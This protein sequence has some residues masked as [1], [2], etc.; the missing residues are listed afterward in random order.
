MSV[1]SGRII[2]G[3]SGATYR[4]AAPQS[5]T[6]YRTE[7]FRST[8]GYRGGT[9]ILGPADASAPAP[10][11]TKLVAVPANVMASDVLRSGL[12][13]HVDA[14]RGV[15]SPHVVR[16][17]DRGTMDGRPFV[18]MDRLEGADATKARPTDPMRS[19]AEAANGLAAIH[20]AEAIHGDVRPSHL[21]QTQEGVRWVGFGFARPSFSVFTRSQNLTI[22]AP[23]L[24]HWA[25]PEELAGHDRDRDTDLW[26]LSA[27]A[28]WLLTGSFAFDGDSPLAIAERVFRGERARAGARLDAVFDRAFSMDRRVRFASALDLARALRSGA[29]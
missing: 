6:L 18:V 2:T 14:L 3:E 25:S 28:F 22:V 1:A 12:E 21:V 20:A 23:S 10:L 27:T 7:A 11:L 26:G 17:H 8:G 29:S 9:A 24:P 15:A 19:L 16:V 13:R 4:L 5:P